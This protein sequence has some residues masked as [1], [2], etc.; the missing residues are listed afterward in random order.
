MLPFVF[1]S[2]AGLGLSYSSRDKLKQTVKDLR[3]TVCSK[4]QLEN[5]LESFAHFHW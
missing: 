3:S 4:G 2:D 5:V 1:L